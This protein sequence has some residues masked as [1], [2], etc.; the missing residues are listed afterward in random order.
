MKRIKS[1]KRKNLKKSSKENLKKGVGIWTE[2]YRKNPHRLA[3]EYLNL[4]LYPF[5]CFLLYMMNFSSMF[6]FIASR[7]LGKSFLTAVF[8]VIRCILYPET[9]IVLA[10]GSKG[11]AELIITEHIEFM[12]SRSKILDKEIKSIKDSGGKDLK[13]TFKNG[14]TI[15][16]S[17]SKD[18]GR[19]KRCNILINDEYRMIKEE[20]VESVLKQFLTRPR[21]PKYLDKPEYS[22][23]PREK[24][25]ELYLSSAWYKSH[26]SYKTFLQALEGMLD[27]D[28]NYFCCD[29]PYICSLDHNLIL[30]EKLDIDKKTMHPVRFDMEYSALWFGENENSYFKSDEINKCRVLK[31]PFIPL[32]ESEIIEGV[33]VNKKNKAYIKKKGEIRIVSADI[34]IVS[35]EANDNSVYTLLRMLPSEN[36]YIN[37]VVWVESH[38]GKSPEY[39]AM[40]LKELYQ[41]FNADKII[42]DTNGNGI[43]VFKEMQKANY[44][45]D[46]DI[47]YSAY[48]NYNKNSDLDIELSKGA[49]P[50]IYALKPNAKINN[51]IAVYLKGSFASNKIRLLLDDNKKRMDLEA[52]SAKFNKMSSVEQVDILEPFI[53][54]TTLV[55]EMINL[56]YEAS[57]GNL[58]IVEKGGNRKDRYSSLAYANYLAQMI[59]TEYLK[60]NRSKEKSRVLFFT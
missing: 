11:Q 6:V 40:R 16:A 3:F 57:G 33:D 10:S 18:T 44:N 38:N 55:N 30:Q 51:D 23:L 52:N 9:K 45:D 27:G 60:K 5:Q 29:I 8:C 48:T 24:N 58:K 20:N 15:L 14:S 25:K 56:E 47:H 12:R 2:Y 35:G 4:N 42:M 22:K 39:Q 31:T 28:E 32:T 46:L 13:C 21:S 41:E 50:V 49:L 54:I 36:G 17:V 37:E 1:R 34:A 59:E 43:A 53:E 26:W 7:G 19:G